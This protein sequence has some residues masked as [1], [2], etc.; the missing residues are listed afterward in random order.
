M[1]WNFTLWTACGNANATYL[2]ACESRV[3]YSREESSFRCITVRLLPCPVVL[4]LVR[5]KEPFP[6]EMGISSEVPL[7]RPLLRRPR[8]RTPAPSVSGTT[9]FFPR[10]E[11]GV[12]IETRRVSMWNCSKPTACCAA[13]AGSAGSQTRLRD[14]GPSRKTGRHT[15]PHMIRP[16]GDTD[17][18]Y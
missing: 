1:V 17:Q 4:N 3:K 14:A 18:G 13:P 5:L 16:R 6:K 15:G 7:K 9:A 12:R 11:G 2:S 10:N 8:E